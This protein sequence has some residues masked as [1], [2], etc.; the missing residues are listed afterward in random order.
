MITAM[1]LA[2]VIFVVVVVT[3]F[4][5]V[6]ISITPFIISPAVVSPVRSIAVSI[7]FVVAAILIIITI[8]LR[9][10]VTVI[11]HGVSPIVGYI[12]RL[13]VPALHIS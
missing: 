5:S 9:T 6:I 13:L 1:L 11:V 10:P 2:P 3:T 12:L 8:V 7:L 4:A